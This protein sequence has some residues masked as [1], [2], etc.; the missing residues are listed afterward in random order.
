VRQVTVQR[1]LDPREFTVVAYGGSGPMEAASMAAELGITQIVIPPA[2]GVFSALSMLGADLRR[3]YVRTLFIRL[4]DGGM[5]E[6]EQQLAS[7]EAEGQ[8]MLRDSGFTGEVI[9]ER[10][11]D[12]RYVRFAAHGWVD[13]AVYVR[14][15]LRYG[16]VIDGPAVI[17]EAQSTTLI[18][19]GNQ[20]TVHRLASFHNERWPAKSCEFPLA[21]VNLVMS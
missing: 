7:L 1:G 4:D 12:M 18:P 2:P 8:R 15:A 9:F 14:S 10:S 16:N 6:L 19:P 17:E 5:N 3:D 11:A 21:T 20:V 13:S